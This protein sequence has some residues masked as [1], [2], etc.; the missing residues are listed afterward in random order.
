MIIAELLKGLVKALIK[1]MQKLTECEWAEAWVRVLF[2]IF[3]K[4][5]FLIVLVVARCQYGDW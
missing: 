2:F 4:G 3:L 5:N 1:A